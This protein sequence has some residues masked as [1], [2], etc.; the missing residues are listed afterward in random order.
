LQATRSPDPS[1]G[2]GRFRPDAASDPDEAVN[3][4]GQYRNAI[5]DPRGFDYR[6]RGGAAGSELSTDESTIADGRTGGWTLSQRLAA[7]LIL[8]GLARLA[9]L[10]SVL[11]TNYP[12]LRWPFGR[13]GLAYF[14]VTRAV[15]AYALLAAVPI[16]LGA[17]M[18]RKRSWV[19]VAG[20]AAVLAALLLE[21][22]LTI[23]GEFG[24]NVGRWNPFDTAAGYVQLATA[25][26]LLATTALVLWTGRA[27][28][29][30]AATLR[31][32][33]S[34]RSAGVLL[35]VLGALQLIVPN[36]ATS[37]FALYPWN[38]VWTQWRFAMGAFARIVVAV[39]VL[40][41]AG[42]GA[43]LLIAGIGLLRSA[44]WAQPIA[45]VVCIFGAALN[46][47]GLGRSG[48]SGVLGTFYALSMVAVMLAAYRRKQAGKRQ[49][50]AM[51][52]TA[53]EQIVH[54]TIPDNEK[55]HAALLASLSA[56][57]VA[58]A[59]YTFAKRLLA[60]VLLIVFTLAVL[61]VVQVGLP[62]LLA[63]EAARVQFA[64][65]VG[66]SFIIS[67]VLYA[68]RRALFAM[69]ARTASNELARADA[70]RPILYLRSFELDRAASNPSGLSVFGFLVAIST[71][72]QKLARQLSRA[73]PVIAIGRPGERLPPLGAAR[74]YVTDELWQQKVADVAK[75]S[76][77]VVWTS[78]VSEGLR[79]EIAHLLADVP[80]QKL[81]LWAHPH[82]TV[83]G[84][85]REAEWS[86]FRTT[87]GGL[88]PKSLPATLGATELFVFAADG[89]PVPVEPR[90]GFL[91]RLLRPFFGALVPSLKTVLAMKAPAA[92]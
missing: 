63:G 5:A 86:L 51:A 7:V 92:P 43:A 53:P 9:L 12:D 3:G 26:I 15:L 25:A 69:R 45:I 54:S 31:P 46:L 8:F 70:R 35:A 20:P 72:E 39:D 91:R 33:L 2:E 36:F 23:Y 14:S 47:Q 10:L 88:F 84:A 75:A 44:S 22:F 50:P 4:A 77:L 57:G 71:P 78:G 76:Q 82:L 16:V 40:A 24:R 90:L 18:L 1:G 58:S 60:G 59:R 66:G 89:T 41:Y 87:L 85:A 81:V 17:A 6:F 27:G 11:S 65:L 55:W 80:A 30:A 38:T 68:I 13:L 79:W 67:P 21:L 61:L 34:L 74:F 64:V 52:P 83:E 56:T 62:G 28:L 42:T 32:S 48:D 49:H 73:G 37:S 19:G 29:P